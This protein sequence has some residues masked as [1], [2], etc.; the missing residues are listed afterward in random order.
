MSTISRDD[1][2]IALTIRAVRSA[3]KLTLKEFAD[4]LG[5]GASTIGKLESGDLTLK[6]SSYMKLQSYLTSNGVVVEYE[7]N[8]GSSDIEVIIKFNSSFIDNMME[9]TS[10]ADHLRDF[11]DQMEK[12]AHD[13]EDLVKKNTSRKEKA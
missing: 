13:L 7:E 2:K 10:R 11:K 12:S 1:L 9:S 8:T 5:L 6:A 3:M 4:I